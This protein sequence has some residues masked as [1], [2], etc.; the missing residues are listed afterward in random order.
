M[1]AVSSLENG[2]PVCVTLSPIL[3]SASAGSVTNFTVPTWFP[4]AGATPSGCFAGA[5]S[6]ALPPDSAIATIDRGATGEQ[7]PADDKRATCASARRCGCRRWACSTLAGWY[8]HGAARG[9]A[10]LAMRTPARSPASLRTRRVHRSRGVARMRAA[11]MCGLRLRRVRRTRTS[12]SRTARPAP[13]GIAQAL[14]RT[15]AG[16][17][18]VG[19]RSIAMR[20]H[21]AV[22][23]SPRRSAPT[24]FASAASAST[25]NR[26][27]RRERA[28]EWDWSQRSRRRTATSP[29]G[30]RCRDRGPRRV[31][32]PCSA[33]RRSSAA[34]TAAAAGPGE[35]DASAPNR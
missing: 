16:G 26:S 28:R 21:R 10:A 30:A 15:G 8:L 14:V 12:T 3:I 5:V 18:G 1:P 2:E 29:A 11:S 32:G 19:R 34:V 25:S 6:L 33:C 24:T 20:G 22:S 35:C 7:D 23:S 31:V 4:T 13:F 27:V 9:D 17:G